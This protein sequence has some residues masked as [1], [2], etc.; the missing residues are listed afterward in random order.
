MESSCGCL[1]RVLVLTFVRKLL[2]SSSDD[3]W[4]VTGSIN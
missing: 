1:T 4:S 2:S 3:R